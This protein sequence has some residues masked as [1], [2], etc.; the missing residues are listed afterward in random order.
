MVCPRTGDR[1]AVDGASGRLLRLSNG[2]AEAG[3][4]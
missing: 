3:D 4:R 1:Y 2:G